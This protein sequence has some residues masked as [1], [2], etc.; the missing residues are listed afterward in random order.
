[1]DQDWFDRR[2]V[3]PVLLADWKRRLNAEQADT[4]RSLELV[5]WSLKFVRTEMGEDTR[6]QPSTTRT[7]THLASSNPMADW[8]RNPR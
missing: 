3:R 6:S 1:M 5:G 4:L 7:T 8:S 2:R